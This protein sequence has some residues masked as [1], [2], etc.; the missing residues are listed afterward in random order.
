MFQIGVS[1]C[2]DLYYFLLSLIMALIGSWIAQDYISKLIL[3]KVKLNLFNLYFLASGAG[4][5]IWSI[6][7]IGLLGY[8]CPII[9]QFDIV[10]IATS[11]IFWSVGIL[12]V[13]YINTLDNKS[14]TI[15]VISGLIFAIAITS[16][17][18]IGIYSIQHLGELE[19]NWILVIVSFGFALITAFSSLLYFNN[20][21]SH[22][23]GEKRGF[24]HK[25]VRSFLI[26]LPLVAVQYVLLAATS[27]NSEEEYIHSINMDYSRMAYYI[28]L[29]TLLI[30]ISIII[31]IYV[32]RERIILK[33][34]LVDEKYQSLFHSSPLIVLELDNQGK[35]IDVNQTFLMMT[36]Y[37]REDVIKQDI[38]GLF[39]PKNKVQL[40]SAIQ[41]ALSENPTFKELS[42]VKKSGDPIDLTVTLLPIIQNLG[43]PGFYLIGKDVSE[44]NEVVRKLR[45]A[46]DN[47]KD[48]IKNQLSVINKFKKDG[49]CYVH[50]VI[51]GQLLY[52][53]GLPPSTLISIKLNELPLSDEMY[54]FHLK[55][56]DKA[57]SGEE[58]TYESYYKNFNLLSF[59]K[60]VIKDGKTVEVISTIVDITQQKMVEKEM[61]IAKEEADQASR[62]KSDFLSKMNH[63]LRT[64]L[65][66]VLGFTQ[67]LEMDK[68]LTEEQRSHVKEILFAGRHLSNLINS[69]LDLSRNDSGLMHFKMEEVLI[70]PILQQSIR[71]VESQATE[72]KVNLILNDLTTKSSIVWADSTKLRQLFINLLDNSIKYNSN[73]GSV[74]IN[75]IEDEKYV[76]ITIKDTGIGIGKGELKKVFEPFY[77]SV[78]M[79]NNIPG[80][81]IGLSI[82]NQIIQEFN[83]SISLTSELGK[84]T[85]LDIKI[86]LLLSEEENKE[87]S[88]MKAINYHLNIPFSK[89]L[90]IEDNNMNRSLIENLFRNEHEKIM[91]LYAKTGREGL[92]L[93]NKEDI[94]L[95]LLD[96]SLSDMNGLEIIDI[97][98]GKEKNQ[99]PIIVVSANA[100]SD[101][102]EKALSVGCSEYITKPIDVGLL[103][104]LLN[105]YLRR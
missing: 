105:Q 30:F 100:S 92:E 9:P 28:G 61:L 5:I 93:L 70:Q 39:L 23:K 89:I 64:P 78:N 17:H 62:A 12:F 66:G 16:V 97:L 44:K 96:V 27:F 34:K 72:L 42:I 55:Q 35:I 40:Q 45:R 102:I 81:G 74:F 79:R 48:I 25:L 84:G 4:I 83:G 68:D 43:M 1:D 38:Y 99:V 63:E 104:K 6:T 69:V 85:K 50:T 67:V 86:P 76:Y 60:P 103:F 57:W 82:V 65:N 101:D 31:V 88:E 18:F 95:I 36:R 2:S 75:T 7:I 15:Y 53:L 80:A 3:S 14:K 98:R 10:L 29:A 21:R 46:E 19:F 77:R 49:S 87:H 47:L 20:Q 11:F 26:G 32:D 52:K 24:Y 59:L 22:K 54:Q 41:E 37:T 51:D 91:I 71:M 58:V 33:K 90:Y 56:Y 73:N 94:D 13:F 8:Q